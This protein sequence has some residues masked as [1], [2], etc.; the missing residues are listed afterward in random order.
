M[1][2]WKRCIVFLKV[3]SF[4]FQDSVFLFWF[5][6]FVFGSIVDLQCVPISAVQQSDSVIHIIDIHFFFFN[7]LLWFV[8]GDWISFPVLYRST[9]LLIPCKCSYWHLPTPNSQCIPVSPPPP[10]QP[11][12]WCLCLWVYFYFIEGSFVP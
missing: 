6:D 11:R 9:L 7:F 5:Q 1:F 8:P 4:W 12:V 2:L 3:F 10:W